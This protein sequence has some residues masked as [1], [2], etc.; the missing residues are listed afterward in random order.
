MLVA[1]AADDAPAISAMGPAGELRE[2][3][4]SRGELREPG[5]GDAFCC[6]SRI[7]RARL[8]P[9]SSSEL[10]SSPSPSSPV[11]SI[12]NMAS[13]E[14]SSMDA[15]REALREEDAASPAFDVR[16]TFFST[17][18]ALGISGGRGDLPPVGERVKSEYSPLDGMRMA[19]IRGVAP[20]CC[21]GAGSL[22]ERDILVGR[23]VLEAAA[24]GAALAIVER[25][26]RSSV[27]RA[28]DEVGITAH[29]GSNLPVRDMRTSTRLLNRGRSHTATRPCSTS[30][31]SPHR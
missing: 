31:C 23:A 16:A 7:M 8:S 13:R 26:V 14:F 10:S 18:S 4:R 3:G 11:A 19:C 29:S 30:A 1:A 28:F 9:S 20:V 2:L 6:R 27:R 22:T 12:A 21:V 5:A 17:S 15:C 25:A 24:A